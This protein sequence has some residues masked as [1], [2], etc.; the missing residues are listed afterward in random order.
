M[1][2]PF[3][4]L[5]RPRNP[6]GALKT[7]KE[8]EIGGRSY[9]VSVFANRFIVRKFLY[10]V[11][12]SASLHNKLR[13]LPVSCKKVYQHFKMSHLTLQMDKNFLIEYSDS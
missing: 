4:N 7:K 10:H 9:N 3:Y 11:C 5:L 6:L 12:I 13:V 1:I 2:S 8:G